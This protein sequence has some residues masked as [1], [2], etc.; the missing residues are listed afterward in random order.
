M[1]LR[2]VIKYL[3]ALPTTCVGAAF[4]PLALISG[5]KLRVHTG[6][7]EIT[8]GFAA[9]FLRRC[10][11]LKG[12]ASAMTL[13]HIVIARDEALAELT[14]DHER[15]HVHQVER[16]GPFFLPAYLLASLW[17]LIRRKNAYLDNPFEREAFD[18]ENA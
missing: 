15:V 11:V 4:V 9:F 5:G 2:G 14:R 12:G 18:R 17:L 13:G 8:G 10:T 3:W 16:W 1:T 7:L 6:V